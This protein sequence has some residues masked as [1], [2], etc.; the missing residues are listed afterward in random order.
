MGSWTHTLLFLILQKEGG[1][2]CLQQGICV[3]LDTGW[4]W[5]V[6][7]SRNVTFYRS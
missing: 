4:A 5:E 1:G 2:V 3:A 6:S 7:D